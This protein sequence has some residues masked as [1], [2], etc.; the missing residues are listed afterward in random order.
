M[1]NEPETLP[2]DAAAVAVF[3]TH[4][5]AESAVKQLQREGFPM[6]QLSLV[7]KDFHTEEYDIARAFRD[8][9][10]MP[11]GGGSSEIMKEIIWKWHE[12]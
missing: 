2:R 7:G 11:I 4:L 10:I 3:D 5:A 12:A 6:N 9:R 1:A 8:V